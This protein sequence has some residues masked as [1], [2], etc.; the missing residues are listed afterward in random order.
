MRASRVA[1]YAAIC[2]MAVA[3]ASNRGPSKQVMIQGAWQA[4]FEGQ[5]MTLDY[6][7]S[8]VSIEEF[9]LSFPY[10]WV[11]DDHIRLNALGQEVISHVEFDGP[12]LMR[13]TT[14]GSTQ[15]LRRVR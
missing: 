9:G 7:V 12:D 11:D 3:C 1:T 8:E 5:A 6:S 4:E 10:Q 15:E 2:L 14:D 13:Q